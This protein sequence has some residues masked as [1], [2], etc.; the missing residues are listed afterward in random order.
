MPPWYR[1]T[2]LHRFITMLRTLELLCIKD[3][4]DLTDNTIVIFNGQQIK[5]IGAVFFASTGIFLLVTEYVFTFQCQVFFI[6]FK[7]NVIDST[8][9]PLVLYERNME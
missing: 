3:T 1:G 5:V 9:C 8:V 7:I 4:C 2:T 6:N